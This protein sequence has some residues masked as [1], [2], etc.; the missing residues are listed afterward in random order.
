MS[1]LPPFLPPLKLKFN[2]PG[3]IWK[4]TPRSYPGEFLL[5]SKNTFSRDSTPVLIRDILDLPITS[6]NISWRGRAIKSGLVPKS[7]FFFL[8]KSMPP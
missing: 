7:K 4:I 2:G 5:T 6:Y 1:F 3:A 8:E